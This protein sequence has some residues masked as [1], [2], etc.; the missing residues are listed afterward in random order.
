MADHDP[1][2]IQMV[3]TTL[4]TG[5]AEK[6]L[7]LLCERLRDRGHHIALAFL[8]GEGSLAPDFERLGV[9]VEKIPLESML[10]LPGAVRTLASR[11]KRG[12][13]DL[14]HSH[15]LKADLV[16]ALAKSRAGKVR[17]IAS[18]HNDER[19]LLNPLYSRV[20]GMISKRADRVIV[21]SDHVGRFVARH[22]RVPEE[23]ITRIYYGLEAETFKA[24]AEEME[25]VEEELRLDP[26]VPVMTMVARFAPQKDHASLL[27]AARKLR[28]Q[29]RA[30]RL[31]LVGGDPFGYNK[32][33]MEALC[34][35]LDLTDCVTFTGIRKDV[36]AILG[37]TD[38]FVMPSNWE[39]L[40]LVF[41]EAMAFSLPVVATRVSA[42]PEIVLD[43]ETG[44]LVE[45]R[46]PEALAQALGRMLADPE[47]RKAFGRAG[48]LRLEEAFGL[49]RMVDETERFYI[50]SLRG[51]DF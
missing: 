45:A 26:E 18:K 10:Q 7:L 50:E 51:Q 36:P 28:Q 39:G 17:L 15:L 40:G 49:E 23:K 25:K 30:F 33:K 16:A 11:I 46:D 42:I 31:L 48:R 22:G 3:I 24:S 8:K 29:G 44:L 14:V 47:E 21:L 27:E 5:G 37:V 13:F 9:S 32:E 6:H 20:H 4:D 38:L 12:G 1:L 2:R 43:G 19:A 34:A 41:L 35:S